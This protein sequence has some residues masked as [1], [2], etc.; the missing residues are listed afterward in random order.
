MV[1]N[2]VLNLVELVLKIAD[3]TSELEIGLYRCFVHLLHV[4]PSWKKDP[5][6]F[7]LPEFSSLSPFKDFILGDF[8]HSNEGS[9]D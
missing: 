3:L 1:V 8:T 9:K 4:C 7:A 5:S 6:S 2:L